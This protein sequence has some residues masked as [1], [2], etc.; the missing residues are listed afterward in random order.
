MFLC[1]K[2][3]FYMMPYITL[4]A[5]VRTSLDQ[6]SD[7]T[8]YFENVEKIL[9]EFWMKME[10]IIRKTLVVIGHVYRL[11]LNLGDPLRY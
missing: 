11:S 6:K 9:V 10:T 2:I 7:S 3:S 1:L 5:S 4:S 8:S